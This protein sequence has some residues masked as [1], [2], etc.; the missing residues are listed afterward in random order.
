MEVQYNVKT[1]LFSGLKMEISRTQLGFRRDRFEE[2][3]ICL[4]RE[5]KHLIG[6]IAT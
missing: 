3:E 2:T 6:W 4:A 5:E 1:D